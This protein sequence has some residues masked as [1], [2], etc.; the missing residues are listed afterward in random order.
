M[1]IIGQDTLQGKAVPL[2]KF[3]V[4]DIKYYSFS[5]SQ[6]LHGQIQLFGAIFGPNFGKS[7]CIYTNGS[8]HSNYNSKVEAD[9]PTIEDIKICKNGLEPPFA[10]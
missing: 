6:L 3:N 2:R 1:G 4:P 7:L 10:K 8:T 9:F 5:Q